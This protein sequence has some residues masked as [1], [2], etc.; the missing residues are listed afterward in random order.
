MKVNFYEQVDDK[1]LRFA[2]IIAR[3]NG[4]WYF[5]NTGRGTPMNFLEATGNRER[6]F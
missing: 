3:Y 1:L 2:V 5:V 4:G 6:K